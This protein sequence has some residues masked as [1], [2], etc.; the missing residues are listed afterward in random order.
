[1]VRRT[2]SAIVLAVLAVAWPAAAD[3][4]NGTGTGAAAG[5]DDPVQAPLAD[6]PAPGEPWWGL[7]LDPA[8]GMALAMQ[9]TGPTV[10]ELIGL[11]FPDGPANCH[12]YY[13]NSLNSLSSDPWSVL[14]ADPE[15]CIR[16]GS[17]VASVLSSVPPWVAADQLR[18]N[19]LEVA[20]GG[21][22]ATAL[23]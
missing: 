18:V 3:L 11:A 19:S 16:D 1:M 23:L 10:E 6:A 15:G 9:R 22:V 13:L 2:L 21:P 14:V 8:A 12:P 5:T 20:T 7:P 17:Y 4:G